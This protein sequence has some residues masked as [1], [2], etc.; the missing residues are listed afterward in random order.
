VEESGG[1][2]VLI[3]EFHHNLDNKNRL[4]MPSKILP[5][6]GNEVIVTR[7]FE[8]CLLVYPLEK[9]DE[10]VSKFRCLTI[11]KSDTRKFM[12]IFLSGATSC[13]FDAQNRIC[14][15]SI[16]K[17]YASISKNVV[18][19]GLDDHLEIWSEELY[20]EFLNENLEEFADIAE[21]IYE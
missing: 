5:N 3:G 13:K 2:H 4:M 17:D 20:T 16:L 14:I 8:K 1:L 10:V 18:I 11:T 19:L 12:R 9:W 7:G 15:P 6:L 21:K